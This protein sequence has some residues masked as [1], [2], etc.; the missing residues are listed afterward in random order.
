MASGHGGVRGTYRTIILGLRSV[1]LVDACD[2]VRCEAMDGGDEAISVIMDFFRIDVRATRRTFA[3]KQADLKRILLCPL[4]IFSYQVF[5]ISFK[6]CR[7][8]KIMPRFIRL[9]KF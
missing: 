6:Y 2:R 9:N 8:P 1:Y 3:S 7:K 4:Y 5:K